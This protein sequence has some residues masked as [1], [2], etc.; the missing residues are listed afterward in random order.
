ML[1]ISSVRNEKFRAAVLR[2]LNGMT[3]R[4]DRYRSTDEKGEIMAAGDRKRGKSTAT[5]DRVPEFVTPPAELV[6]MKLTT[7]LK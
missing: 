6:S 7:P 3:I 5:R 1:P 2:S 4:R